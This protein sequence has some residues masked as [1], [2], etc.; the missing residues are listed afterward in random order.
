[1]RVRFCAIV[2]LLN[3]A[4]F[5][6]AQIAVSDLVGMVTSALAVDRDD[7]RIAQALTQV[8]LRERLSDSTVQ[9]LREMGAGRATVRELQE[10]VRKSHVL[11]P[12]SEEPIGTTPEPSASERAAMLH[13]LRTYSSGYLAS[14]PDF[15][16]T[17]EARQ[18]RTAESLRPS[19]TPSRRY[20]SEP[21]GV[22]VAAEDKRWKVSGSYTVEVTYARG[23]DHYRLTCVDDKP[24]RESF[25][26]LQKRVSWGEFSG[27]LKDVYGSG[28]RFE[29]DRWEVADGKRSAVLIYSVDPAHSGYWLCCPR[30]AAAHRG[31]VYVD[32]QS[33]AVRRIIIYG[34]KL[35]NNSETQAAGYVLNYGE[36]TIGDRRYLMPRRSVAYSR[37]GANEMREEIDYSGYRKFA[38][39][40]TLSFPK[41]DPPQ[42]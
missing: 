9:M 29:W 1:M 13:A 36:V 30:F 19:G 14:L 5:A 6:A 15:I 16:C 28:A 41:G 24:T 35:P 25:D 17:R 10:L 38:A 11:P 33:G 8:R 23:A 22:P 12:P 37:S 4:A 32:P 21:R 34:I 20:R 3:A 18:F 27:A 31:F 39:D 40:S 26:Q 2:L 42:P 7:Q